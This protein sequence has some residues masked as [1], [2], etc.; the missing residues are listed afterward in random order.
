MGK[1][2]LKQNFEFVLFTDECRAT[3]DGPDGWRR[4]WC[5]TKALCPQRIRRQQGGGGVMF[6]AAII[7]D[8]LV[9][10]FRIKDGVKMTAPTYIAFLRE[11][12][13]PW[14]KKKSLAFCNKMV[15]MHHTAH[16]TTRFLKKVLVKKGEI[17]EWPACSPNLNPI[18][19]LWSILKREVYA[20]G[21]QYS[22]KEDLWNAIKTT[23]KGISSDTIKKLT[24]SMD[25][26]LLSVVSNH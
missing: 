5:D 3:L 6:W 7:H 23:A 4:E 20:G 25:R 8:E 17:M 2:Y 19:N 24:S 26:R 16:V 14:Y 12:W 11:H 15:F 1:K 10:P 18:E 21:K 9:G 13:L 22:S